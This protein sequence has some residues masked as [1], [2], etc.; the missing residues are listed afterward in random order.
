MTLG[1]HDVF[2]NPGAWDE[3][4]AQ[5]WVHAL[6]LRAGSPDQVK[7]RTQLIDLSKLEAGNTVV[8]IG[9]GTG[10]LLC[11]IARNV[12]ATGH[13]VGIEPQPVFADAARKRLAL[14]GFSSFAEVQTRA[15][16]R[17]EIADGSAAA[18]LAQTVL[19]HLP[20]DALHCC[21]AEMVRIVQSRGRVLSVDPDGDTWTIDHPDRGLTRRIVEFN[22]D[23]RYADGWTGRRLLRLFCEAGLRDV[24][25]HPFTQVDT[26]SS[27]YLFGMAERIADAA[28][29]ARVISSDEARQWKHQLRELAA[30][31]SFFSSISYFACIGIRT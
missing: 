5:S 17:L 11:D 16:G 30:R 31:G 9:C 8:E 10:A 23:Q 28:A 1:R 18:C 15:A 26:D 25:I 21:L 6:E 13:V 7:L 4:T 2:R 14:A 20:A 27:S 29:E 22:S 12:G 24:R 19:I 3:N